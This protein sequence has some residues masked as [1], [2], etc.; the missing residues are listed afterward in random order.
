MGDTILS[1]NKLYV[2]GRDLSSVWTAIALLGGRESL[3]FTRGS[4]DT[5]VYKSG[6]RVGSLEVE[7]ITEL[8]TDLADEEIYNAIENL[9]G[10][11]IVVGLAGATS[12]EAGSAGYAMKADV[13]DYTPV[14]GAVGDPMKFTVS[15]RCSSRIVRGNFL[16]DG[17][18]VR[19]ATGNGAAFQIGAVSATQRVF[20]TIVCVSASSGDTL[21]VVLASDDQEA[22][23]GS[24]ST[25]ITFTQIS[26]TGAYEWKELAG[27]ITDDWWRAQHTIAGNGSEA[28]QYVLL[29]AIANV[30]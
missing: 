14:E 6:L 30:P 5:R 20:A 15:A 4:D 9:S 29:V 25:R 2:A 26:A 19:N 28:F 11:S 24:P 27:P 22:F 17:D 16:S 1:K 23:A 3:E 7:G 10:A 8:G 13:G 18:T 21:D 12:G